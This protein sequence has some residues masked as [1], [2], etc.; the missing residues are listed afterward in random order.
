MQTCPPRSIA[1]ACVTDTMRGCAAITAG[2]QTC[3]IGWNAKRSSSSTRSYSP[4][5]AHR[6]A[7]HDTAR[8]DARGDQVDDRLGDH[9]GMDR[10]IAAV[11][12]VREHLVRHATDADLERRTVVD[13]PRDVGGD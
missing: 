4:A 8:D 2:S 7:R 10:E 12:Q 6:P 9:V 3:S 13:Q 11:E 1:K 5:R